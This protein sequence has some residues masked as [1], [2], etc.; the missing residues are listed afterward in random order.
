MHVLC[1]INSEAEHPEG[2][3]LM[4][5]VK[6]ALDTRGVMNPGKMLRT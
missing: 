3:A 4:R 5:A 2:I 6:Q 1:A